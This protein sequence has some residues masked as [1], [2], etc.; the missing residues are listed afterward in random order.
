[1]DDHKLSYLRGNRQF[2][3]LDYFLCNLL[4][5]FVLESE[6]WRISGKL[7]ACSNNGN[8]K[9]ALSA[10]ENLILVAING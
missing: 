9:L 10:A 8:G 4:S 3:I 5:F 2:S 1:M 7:L 6:T